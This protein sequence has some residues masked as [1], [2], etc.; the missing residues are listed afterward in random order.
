MAIG[1][2]EQEVF[3]GRDI[4]QRR[5]VS[6]QTAQ[7]VDGEVKR[8]LDEAYDI[9]RHVL[10]EHRDAAGGASRWRCWSARRSTGSRWSCWRPGEELPPPLCSRAI[11]RRAPSTA[12]SPSPASGPATGPGMGDL[13]PSV[14]REDARS[15]VR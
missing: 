5:Q 9:A 6:E 3:L 14:A 2:S 12:P 10:E 11:R 13:S 8:L 15:R 7:L 4:G 1:D